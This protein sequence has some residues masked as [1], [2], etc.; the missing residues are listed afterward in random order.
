M[1]QEG[2]TVLY[3][4]VG[5]PPEGGDIELRPEGAEGGSQVQ[6]C[7]KSSRWREQSVQSPGAGVCLACWR[8]SKEACVAGAE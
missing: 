8:N 4:V 5:R 1:G 6:S 7:K 3:S 2:V